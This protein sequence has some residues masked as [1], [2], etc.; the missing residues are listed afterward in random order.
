MLA[1]VLA[2]LRDAIDAE[3]MLRSNCSDRS[4]ILPLATKRNSAISRSRSGRQAIASRR[5]SLSS[6]AHRESSALSMLTLSPGV[7]VRRRIAF[8]MAFSM[9]RAKYFLG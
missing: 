3:R 7:L 6:G 9:E 1:R 5:W 8:S 4:E 2:S